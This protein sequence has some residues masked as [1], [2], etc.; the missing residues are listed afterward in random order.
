MTLAALS[1]GQASCYECLAPTVCLSVR[2]DVGLV[3]AVRRPVPTEHR[4]WLLPHCSVTWSVL[5]SFADYSAPENGATKC[6]SASRGTQICLTSRVSTSCIWLG[7][8]LLSPGV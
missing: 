6:S 4:C 5:R 7:C 1:T 2:L 8:A 3:R